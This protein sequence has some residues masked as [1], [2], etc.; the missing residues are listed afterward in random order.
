VELIKYM[1]PLFHVVSAGLMN[2]L[3][4]FLGKSGKTET[5]MKVL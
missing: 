4:H 1:E 5:M 2:Q 3:L